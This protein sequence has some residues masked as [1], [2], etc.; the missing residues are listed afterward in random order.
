MEEKVQIEYQ[1]LFL[2]Y[3]SFNMPGGDSE[4]TV[5]KKDERNQPG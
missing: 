4:H 5:G 1:E 3:L 2:K